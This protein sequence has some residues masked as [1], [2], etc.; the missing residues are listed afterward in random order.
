MGG[1]ELTKFF[2][3]GFTL[4]PPKWNLMNETRQQWD[5]WQV[6]H[7]SLQN[8][9]IK[10]EMKFH[11]KLCLCHRNCCLT[12]SQT[13]ILTPCQVSS[14]H[15]GLVL[16]VR[17]LLMGGWSSV[18]WEP[19]LLNTSWLSTAHLSYILKDNIKNYTGCPFNLEWKVFRTE[20]NLFPIYVYK[21]GVLPYLL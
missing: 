5:F 8:A 9:S 2:V 14:L 7:V 11:V 10:W 18:V 15:L 21:T 13:S 3:L 17:V 20:M 4:Y 12:C 6:I 19:E 1:A 16:T